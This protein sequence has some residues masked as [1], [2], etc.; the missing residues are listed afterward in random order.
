MGEGGKQELSTLSA[1]LCCEPKLLLR[2]IKRGKKKVFIVELK[3]SFNRCPTFLFAK[4]SNPVGKAWRFQ[5]TKIIM[6]ISIQWPYCEPRQVPHVTDL[7]STPVLSR[8]GLDGW[9]PPALDAS[10]S[11]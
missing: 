2:S 1:P 4:S 5:I 11:L 9:I 8:E 7:L 3:F 10:G 6:K